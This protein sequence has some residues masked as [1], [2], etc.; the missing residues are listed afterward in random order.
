MT[1]SCKCSNLASLHLCHDA[2]IVQVPSHHFVFLNDVDFLP[3]PTLHSS[4]TGTGRWAPE[5]ARMR[6][7]WHTAGARFTFVVPAFER[8]VAV[9]G[10]NRTVVRDAGGQPLAAPWAGACDAQDGCEVLQVRALRAVL[11]APCAILS[12]SMVW[13]MLRILMHACVH[14]AAT[15]P[16][17]SAHLVTLHQLST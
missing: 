15:G 17:A 6:A 10:P 14:N 11:Q 12:C 16:T 8:L 13:A 3:T 2:I 1:S 7:A 4:L 5:L 9:A